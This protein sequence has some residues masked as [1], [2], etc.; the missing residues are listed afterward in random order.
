M[1]PPDAD[2]YPTASGPAKVI[3]DAHSAEQSLKLYSGWFCPF[4]QRV[5][6]VLEEKKIPYQYIEV[7]PYHK[8][9]SLLSL[10]PRGLVPT[11]A[12]ENKPLYESTVICEFLEDAYPDYGVKLL[13]AEP[14]LRARM[15]IWVDFV[16]TRVLPAFHRFLQFQPGQQG[17]KT[18]ED[19]RSGFLDTLRQFAEAMDEEGPFFLGKDPTLVDYVLAPWAVRLWIFDHFKEGGLGLPGEGKGQQDE[20]SWAR[21]R[22]WLG[23]IEGRKS[24]VETTSDRQNYLPIYQR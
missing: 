7:N 19:V 12:Y 5:W 10:N 15:R 6:I 8:P 23:A 4:V 2:L 13:P 17:E 11:L 20:K 21:F 1:P 18:I 24:I 14:Y 3:V 9:E 22:K 16:S